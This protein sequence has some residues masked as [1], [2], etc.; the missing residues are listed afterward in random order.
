MSWVTAAGG[1]GVAGIA[2]RVKDMAQARRIIAQQQAEITAARALLREQLANDIDVIALAKKEGSYHAL[3]REALELSDRIRSY[4]D[5]CDTL[6][7][8]EVKL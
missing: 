2:E 7:N 1:P 4:L 8:G 5:A 3:P 6:G